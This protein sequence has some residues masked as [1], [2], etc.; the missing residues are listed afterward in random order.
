MEIKICTDTSS[1]IN[2]EELKRFSVSEID[3]PVIFDGESDSCKDTAEFWNKLIDGK[4]ART[5]QPNPETLKNLFESAKREGYALICIL[6]SSR[7]SGTFESAEAVKREVGYEN[8]YII[9]S[10]NA[11]VG[12]RLLVEYACK[13]RDSG[14]S[15]EEIVA[16]TEELKPKIRLFACI[17]TLKYLARGGRIT[18]TSAN[19]GTVL[20]VK[21]LVTVSDGCVQVFEKAIGLKTAM[22]RLI[23]QIKSE[24]IDINFAPIPLFAFDDKNCVEFVKRAN[25]LGFNIDVGL[26]TPIGAT[27][28]AHIGPGGFG[29]VFVSK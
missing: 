25:D 8:I 14:F 1:D 12:V 26:R 29:I 6:I 17:D 7:L 15:A 16:K 2:E 22:K 20:N 3:L 5:S 10:L 11:T 24:N 23:T 9:D 28:G 4:V 13:L 18:K 27:I 21:P 19:L